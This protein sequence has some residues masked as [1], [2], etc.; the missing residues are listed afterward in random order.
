AVFGAYVDQIFLNKRAGYFT[1]MALNY[2]G[3][4]NLADTA[5]TFKLLP[6]AARPA[7]LLIER[8]HKIEIGHPL[9]RTEVRPVD[10]G[11]LD[12]ALSAGW[13]RRRQ[14][15]KASGASAKSYITSDYTGGA[16]MNSD[17][18]S[19]AKLGGGLKRWR[20][21]KNINGYWTNTWMNGDEAN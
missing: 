20:V 1:V 5:N 14:G 13:M 10:G 18:D 12:V 7:D 4:M 17:G 21:A 16:G 6:Q 15:V 11:H 19:Y 3:S 8:W 2:L 9:V